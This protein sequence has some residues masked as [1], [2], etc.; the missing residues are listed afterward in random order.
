MFF[1]TLEEMNTSAEYW[2]PIAR[3]HASLDRYLPTSGVILQMTVGKSHPINAS[4]LEK[5]LQ[6][7][8]F[9]KWEDKNPTERIKF[10]FVL[11]GEN[12]DINK[13]QSFAFGES[14][15]KKTSE[16]LE[17]KRRRGKRSRRQEAIELRIEQYTLR[18]D[19]E[20]RLKKLCYSQGQKRG[21]DED[22]DAIIAYKKLKPW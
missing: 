2:R 5:A 7:K 4:G 17:Q 15:Q 20:G 8:V 9:A 19:L 21:R 12:D 1:A 6:S 10:I 3:N 13:K 22:E 14:E 18:V 16:E 11:D